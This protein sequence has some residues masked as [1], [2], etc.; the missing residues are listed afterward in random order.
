[1]MALLVSGLHAPT[2]PPL[3]RQS[4]RSRIAWIDAARA[5][6]IL[7]IVLGHA[8]GL[9][10]WFYAAASSFA[11]PVFFIL[12]GVLLSSDR[13]W[14]ASALRLL[15]A[16][17]VPY[18]AIGLLTW[19]YWAATIRMGLRPPGGPSPIEGLWGLAYGVGDFIPF[20]AALWFLPCLLWASLAATALLRLVPPIA[21]LAIALPPAIWVT[22]LAIPLQERLPWSIEPAV[23]AVPFLL[24]GCAWF[25]FGGDGWVGQRRLRSLALLVGGGA[26]VAFVTWA[27]GPVSLDNLQFGKPSL[28]WLGAVGGI[29]AVRGLAGLLP[30]LALL[31][32]I[33]IDTR[34][35]FL[36]HQPLFGV[37]T[38]VLTLAFGLPRSAKETPL[39][40]ILYALTAVALLVPIGALLRRFVPWLIGERTGRRPQPGGTAGL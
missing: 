20:N 22:T 34:S 16:L 29:A 6:A 5:V 11:V 24:L 30:P 28:Y 10:A 40:A 39:A 23:V 8:A 17:V 14:R 36:L 26:T 31:R 32:R 3:L 1:M 37:F 9:P 25:Q 35:V 27:N 19:A 33:A 13:P 7:L 15:R 38:G 4:V 21:A 18:V 2:L 12:S